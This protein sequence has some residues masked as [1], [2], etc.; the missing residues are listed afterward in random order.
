MSQSGGEKPVINLS[1]VRLM[2]VSDVHRR[3]TSGKEDTLQSLS[4][5]LLTLSQTSPGF[6]VSHVQVF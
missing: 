6:Y 3:S 2:Y 5:G 1:S 4:V